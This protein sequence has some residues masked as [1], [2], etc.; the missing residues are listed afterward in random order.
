MEAK[1]RWEMEGTRQIVSCAEKLRGLFLLSSIGPLICVGVRASCVKGEWVQAE[2]GE[3]GSSESEE[4]P[5]LSTHQSHPLSSPFQEGYRRNT[6]TMS[7]TKK[8]RKEETLHTPDLLLVKPSVCRTL[9]LFYLLQSH[10]YLP[11]L[12]FHE[13]LRDQQRLVCSWSYYRASET[14]IRAWT[15]GAMFSHFK[16]N[17]KNNIITNAKCHCVWFFPPRFSAC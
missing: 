9:G 13:R 15:G 14:Y 6:I 5:Y 3:K 4:T 1:E 7:C 10:L 17:G 12:P 8:K 11:L 2:K 16:R